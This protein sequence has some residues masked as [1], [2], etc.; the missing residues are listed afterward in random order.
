MLLVLESHSS[1]NGA[2]SGTCCWCWYAVRANK[3]FGMF[4]ADP[5]AHEPLVIFEAFSEFGDNVSIELEMDSCAPGWAVAA[6]GPESKVRAANLLLWSER[7]QREWQEHGPSA[8]LA[9]GFIAATTFGKD[10]LLPQL[11]RGLEHHI[12]VSFKAG[13]FDP[14]KDMPASRRN[15]R[16][17]E[18]IKAALVFRTP[19]DDGGT[20]RQK[21]RTLQ[22]T[23]AVENCSYQAHWEAMGLKQYL[24]TQRKDYHDNTYYS[25]SADKGRGGRQGAFMRAIHCPIEAPAAS[26][27]APQVGF[28]NDRLT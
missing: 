3:N 9:E 7:L 17:D 4:A 22:R 27:M 14:L 21:A 2:S 10:W 20:G 11:L 28:V 26:W 16:V 1:S 18:A 5:D 24:A 15:S 12:T 8:A 25:V 6:R 19:Q 13:P 23:G